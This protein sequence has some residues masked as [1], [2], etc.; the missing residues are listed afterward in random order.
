[1]QVDGFPLTVEAPP[2]LGEPH[3]SPG[4]TDFSAAD[5]FGAL[6]YMGSISTGDPESNFMRIRLQLGWHGSVPF[7]F[8]LHEGVPI[9]GTFVRANSQ[10]PELTA[11]VSID[12]A[13]FATST[14]GWV[15]NDTLRAWAD[16]DILSFGE[17]NPTCDDVVSRNRLLIGA[18][19]NRMTIE[20]RPGM[21]FGVIQAAALCGHDH[22]NW[23][24]YIRQGTVRKKLSNGS[25]S[26]PLEWNEANCIAAFS[27]R[28]GDLINYQGKFVSIPTPDPPLH[29]WAYQDFLMDNL[30]WYWDEDPAALQVYSW[31]NWV[32]PPGG[33]FK[34]F[35][36]LAFPE[37]THFEFI[38]KLVGIPKAPGRDYLDTLVRWTY[39]GAGD[40]DPGR[41]LLF[42]NVDPNT[43]AIGTVVFKGIVEPEEL[44]D[45]EFLALFGK[46]RTCVGNAATAT[47]V[48]QYYAAILHRPSDAN[49]K[50]FWTGEA[51]RMCALGA[52]PKQTFVVM[53]NFF[54]NA[55]EYF[56]LNRDDNGF[57]TDLYNAFLGRPPDAGGLSYWLGQLSSGIPRNNVMNWFLFSPEFAAT[58]NIAFPGQNP[59]AETYLVLNLYG[60]LLRRLAESGGYT[61]WRGQFRS[62]Q[63]NA[64]PATAVQATIDT[65]S[66]Q[67]VASAEYAARATTNSQ[68]VVDLYYALMQRGAEPGGYSYWVGQLNG[69][70]LTRAQ[71][72]QQFLTSPEMTAQSAAIAAQGCLH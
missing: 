44:T 65:V 46:P 59:R 68:Y 7:P 5:P 20:F 40:F 18:F 69:G 30:P 1:V 6:F 35:D 36:A 38:T 33:L 16:I 23:L 62:A 22:F 70:F 25:L 26:S 9:A 47:L 51:D 34:F 13:L 37:G 56:A 4:Q 49:G 55:P 42:N 8:L 60:G 43:P 71:V 58:M 64:S 24:S 10:D 12:A 57:V 45:A 50:A 19:Q 54:F 31:R 32:F 21:G 66:G 61:Y 67:F 41:V 53:A 17:W 11:A 3:P 39:D 28:C 72:R 2:T 48:E 15:F 52:D 27:S 63:C 29:G 14:S